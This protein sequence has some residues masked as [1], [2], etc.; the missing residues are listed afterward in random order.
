MHRATE[1]LEKESITWDKSKLSKRNVSEC[2]LK[3]DSRL[4][5]KTFGLFHMTD[6]E[7]TQATST[8]VST[9]LHLHTLSTSFVRWQMS[10]LVSDSVPV[11]VV[12]VI[13]QQLFS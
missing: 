12:V 2:L 8:S 5:S 6:A 1:A 4:Q 7:Y 9:G 10:R 13:A 11:V 3:L